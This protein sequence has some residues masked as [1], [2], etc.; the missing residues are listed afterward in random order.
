MKSC[1]AGLLAV[2]L[3]V[4]SVT[5]SAGEL[6]KPHTFATGET[7]RASDFNENFD[8]LY[9]RMNELVV[10][11]DALKSPGSQFTDNGDGTVTDRLSG[12]VWLKNANCFGEQTWDTA[13]A[14]AAALASGQCGLTDGSAA[15]AWRLPTFMELKRFHDFTWP[16]QTTVHPFSGVQ[17]SGEL[18]W[19]GSTN[20]H[21]TSNAWFVRLVDGYVDDSSKAY[22]SLYV[23]PVRGGQ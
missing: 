20:A 19:S 10:L 23:W 12:L 13:M 3:S 5:A 21:Y 18:Y 2:V 11:L 16:V 9:S 1:F 22:G 6:V 7:V 14:S 4:F 8:A 15:G 17:A